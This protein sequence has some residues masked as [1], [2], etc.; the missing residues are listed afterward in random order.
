VYQFSAQIYG[1]WFTAAVALVLLAGNGRP[2]FRQWAFAILLLMFG[3]FSHIGVA[4]LGI[5]WMGIMLLLALR[6]RAPEVWRAIGL[7]ALCVVGAAVFMYLDIIAETLTHTG[8]VLENQAGG[9]L[10]PGATPGLLKGLRLAYSD[11]GIL[12]LPGLLLLLTAR[13]R[14]DRLIVP[15]GL[16]LT[17]LFYLAVDLTLKLQVRYFYFALPLAIALIALA[18]GRLAARGG[19]GRTITWALVA[20]LTLQGLSLWF[21]TTFADG[22]I[23]M[24]PLTH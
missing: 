12:L 19:A 21:S 5:S 23:S 15:L 2:T 10:F 17:V 4:I 24:T 14:L 9:V 8:T 7:F 11:V 16:V 20:V 6:R 18:L 1:Q 3:L 13:P 22:Q